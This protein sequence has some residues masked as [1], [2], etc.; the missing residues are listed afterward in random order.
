MADEQLNVRVGTSYNGSGIEA[1]ISAVSGFERTQTT[2]FGNISQNVANLN[3]VNLNGFQAALQS[4][5]IQVTRLSQAAS[6]ASTSASRSLSQ[7]AAASA[8][9][10]R[11]V[12]AGSNQA[13]VALTNLGRVA[14]DSAFG[15]V[16]IANNLNPMLESFQRLRAETGSNSAALR[17]LGSSLMGAGGLGL[18]LSA[19]QAIVLFSQMGLRAWTGATKEAKAEA[20]D[21]VGSLDAVSQARLKGAQDAQKELTELKVLYAV[22]N[23]ATIALSKRKD[24]VDE[25]QNKYPAYFKNLKDETILNG[26]AKEAYDKLTVS[27]IATAKARAAQDLITKKASSLLLNEEEIKNSEAA[28]AK[29]KKSEEYRIALNKKSIADAKKM[30]DIRAGGVQISAAEANLAAINDKYGEAKIRHE[31]Y[32][33]KRKQ[34]NLKLSQ[35]ILDL[36][37][38]TTAEVKKGADLTGK[39]GG[40]KT[41]KAKKKTPTIGQL[42]VPDD[43][44]ILGIVPS[45]ITANPVLKIV[46]V[47]DLTGV[48]EA[49]AELVETFDAVSEKIENMTSASSLVTTLAEAMSSG[50]SALGEAIASGDNVIQAF[51]NAFLSSFAAFLSELGAMVIKKGALMLAVGIAENLVVPGSGAQS[52]ASGLTLMAAGAALSVIGGYTSAKASGNGGSKS[53]S[54]GGEQPRSIPRFANGV[55]NFAGGLA[56]VGERGPELVNLPMGSSVM[57]NPETRRY[58]KDGG[59]SVVVGGEMKISMRQLVIA[60]RSEEKLMGRTS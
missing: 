14:Q 16:G 33:A 38:L 32:I 22:S 10:G 1:A 40:Q 2:A 27:I 34:L 45:E 7:L 50:F 23:D 20:K 6:S 36:E 29:N 12:A 44:G 35:D 43:F 13:T 26:G 24:A 57:P 55:T 49:Y 5:T 54:N 48:D 21:F 25:L 42:G 59:G 51:G 3:R 4:G 17:T 53:L 30:D 39:V 28:M 56:L 60:L 11:S 8:T 9:S 15:F 47:L 46:P 37:K 31:E 18:A 52:V 19:F 58:M 41:E